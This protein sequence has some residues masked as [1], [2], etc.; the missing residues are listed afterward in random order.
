[1]ILVFKISMLGFL[2]AIPPSL[3]Q[4]ESEYKQLKSALIMKMTNSSPSQD[5]TPALSDQFKSLEQQI[6]S[7]LTPNTKTLAQL[8]LNLLYLET[9]FITAIRQSESTDRSA[10]VTAKIKHLRERFKIKGPHAWPTSWNPDSF[11][12]KFQWEHSITP[13]SI[14]NRWVRTQ[15]NDKKELVLSVEIP[16]PRLTTNLIS[17]EI[18]VLENRPAS[19]SQENLLEDAAKAKYHTDPQS[20]LHS[21]WFWTGVAVLVAGSSSYLIYETTQTRRAVTP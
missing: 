15:K 2:V 16:H 6:F 3:E 14:V 12:E 9:N 17:T 4:F 10:E 1:M 5:S 20:W 13:K 21:P 18:G 11:K 19:S 7:E 8:Y